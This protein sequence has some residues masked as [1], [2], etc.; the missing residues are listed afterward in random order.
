MDDAREGLSGVVSG[1]RRRGRLCGFS[2]PA[3]GVQGS[4]NHLNLPRHASGRE[5][6]AVPYR[7][8]P[9]SQGGNHRASPGGPVPRR[10]DRLALAPRGAALPES[11]EQGRPR[12]RERPPGPVPATRGSSPDGRG[13]SP[14]TFK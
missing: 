14:T 1:R 9:A 7:Q 13:P 11:A 4:L 12:E 8:Y 6:F 2:P 5:S 3:Y 10:R